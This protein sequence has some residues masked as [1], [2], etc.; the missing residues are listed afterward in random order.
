MR[1][2]LI[3]ILSLAPILGQAQSAFPGSWEGVW[4]GTLLIYRQNQLVDSVEMNLTIEPTDADSVWI[5]TTKYETTD[6]EVIKDYRLIIVNPEA[7]EYVVDEQ[8][9]IRLQSTLMGNQL[10]SM[11]RVGEMWLYT[12][13]EKEEEE[14][15]FEVT[16]G[17][18]SEG[19]AEVISDLVKGTQRTRMR[20]VR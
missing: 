5:W 10:V 17:D 12:R 20:K 9:G 4:E 14:L 15:L 8:N 7:G 6:P 2:I 11:F 3:L 19:K 16:Y 18:L 13:Y 1:R